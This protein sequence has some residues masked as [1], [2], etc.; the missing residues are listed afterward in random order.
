MGASRSHCGDLVGDLCG[1]GV[2]S[3]GLDRLQILSSSSLWVDFV[4]AMMIIILS[5]HT[6]GS[7][8]GGM[9]GR[10]EESVND[11]AKT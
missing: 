5:M 11:A 7:P 3:G 2:E 4:Y 8:G 6:T 9:E 1:A 10:R